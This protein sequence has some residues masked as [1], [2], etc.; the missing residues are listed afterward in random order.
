MPR[1][2][3]KEK[4]YV[5]IPT[6]FM[7]MLDA[8]CDKGYTRTQMV[9]M[10]IEQRYLMELAGKRVAKVADTSHSI[11]VP[12][13]PVLAPEPEQR[14]THPDYPGRYFTQAEVDAWPDDGEED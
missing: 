3:P 14:Y 4:L 10:S 12:D 1:Q 7:R 5:D 9:M 2:I 13:E 8:M 6:K 11:E